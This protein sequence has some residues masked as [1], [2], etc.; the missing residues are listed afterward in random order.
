MFV[1]QIFVYGTPETKCYLQTK[2][3]NLV[4]N[5]L[6]SPPLP[7]LCPPE[8]SS[9]LI[10]F[11]SSLSFPSCFACGDSYPKT[12]F[13]SQS[14]D[15]CSWEGVTCHSMTGHVIGLDLSC[16][17]LKESLPSNSSLFL[18]QDLRWPNLAHLEFTGSQIPPEFSKLRSLTYLNLSHIGI[19][20]SVTEHISPLAELGSLDQSSLLL[21]LDNHHF[22]MLVHNLTNGYLPKSN[23]STSLRFLHLSGT[24]FLEELPDSMGNL[25]NLEELDL[26]FCH[27]TGS[28]PLSLGNLTKITFLH[29]KFNNFEGH[30]PDVFGNFK[31]LIKLYFSF[32]N[33][34][35]LLPS[36]AFN[37]TR[38]TDIGLNNNHL[39]GPLPD[40][41]SGLSNRQNLLYLQTCLMAEYQSNFLGR[42]FRLLTFTQIHF[43]YHFQLHQCQYITSSFSENELTGEIPSGFYDITFPQVL[44]LSKNNL[45]G[46]IPKCLGNC[47]SLSVMN[48]RMNNFDGKIPRS[49]TSHIPLSLGKLLALESLDLSSNMIEG[50]ILMQLRN[51]IF[52]AVL[53]LSQNN[54][55]GPVPKGNQFDTFTNN[56]YVGNLRF[57]GFPLSNECGESEG[58]E[59]P[60]S[61]FDED[62]DKGGAFTWKFA[63]MG[64]GC[65]LVLRL[66]MGYIVFTTGKPAWL[67]KIIQRAP[68]QRVR[69]DLVVKMLGFFTSVGSAKMKCLKY[70]E[71]IPDFITES[72]RS[73]LE[74]DSVRAIKWTKSPDLAPWNLRNQVL[75]I[76]VL[77]SKVKQWQIQ[78]AIRSGNTIA[79]SLAKPGVGG[80]QYLLLLH[81]V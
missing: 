58:R 14:R 80:D 7:Q 31:K 64:Y 60:P 70:I 55:M 38:L 6:S 52:L 40:N 65:G 15:C 62:D 33:F 12:E 19:D 9:A 23:R 24:S 73:I 32:N 5:L 43:K 11:K 16:S 68:H 34:H 29:L 76:L 2:P 78:H 54:L 36:S 48:L 71:E 21:K 20:C 49:L 8:H 51:L 77:A 3:N 42:L 72:F 28:I 66:S 17:R 22:N 67:V 30:I 1:V 61:I 75:H 13:W 74:S 53:N 35:G 47:G 39:A 50:S 81:S 10:Q 56:S 37:L 27:F 41:V 69:S 79:D 25:E 18:L 57:C 63:M 44:D 26:S 46:I 59:P 45:S 4:N